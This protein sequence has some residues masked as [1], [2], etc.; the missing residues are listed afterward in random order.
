VLRRL[1]GLAEHKRLG[2][3]KLAERRRLGQQ[4]QSSKDKR[5]TFTFS[6]SAY[7]SYT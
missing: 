2:Q 4:T 3:R 1:G 5:H 7:F 6:S